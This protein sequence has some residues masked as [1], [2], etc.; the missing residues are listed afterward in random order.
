MTKHIL[1]AEDEEQARLFLNLILKKAGY[2]VT[3]VENGVQ[4]LEMLLL[5]RDSENP[6]DLLFTDLKMPRMDGVELVRAVKEKNLGVPAIAI[7]G[8]GDKDAVVQLLRNGCKDYLEKPLSAKD[9]L[10]RVEKVLHETEQSISD[11][12]D[13]RQSG[14]D[15]AR[16]SRELITYKRHLD[17]LSAQFDSAVGAYHQLVAIPDRHVDI[18]FA[19]KNRPLDE[20]GG[21]FIGI[22]T[23]STIYDVLIADVAGHDLGASFHTILIKAFFEENARRQNDGPT[24]F[25]MLNRHLLESGKNQR[26]ITA[27]FLRI[28]ID[29]MTAWLTTAGHPPLMQMPAGS[30]RILRISSEGPV[31]GI[32]ETV[33]F[34]ARRFDIAPGDRLFLYT[35]G[36]TS[37]ARLNTSIGQMEKLTEKGLTTM[38]LNHRNQTLADMI[39]DVW[40]DTLS[41][42]NGKPEDDMLLAGVEIPKHAETIV[43]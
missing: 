43:K 15:P 19:W 29:S 41:F 9:I 32:H 27:L 25:L 5:A 2:H 3:G 28:D 39:A 37:V 30:D 13:G 6:V 42:C 38:L 18:P 34:K 35:D 21:D 4:A 10:D 23:W 26:M 7:T 31:M 8:F 16:L 12:V 22:E 24:L 1:I 36:V 33:D 14:Q 17:R 40:K 20:L 11:M